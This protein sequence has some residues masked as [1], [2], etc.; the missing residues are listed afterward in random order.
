[1][2]RS[3]LLALWII[4]CSS[5]SLYSQATLR[6]EVFDETTGDPLIG[7][8]VVILGTT[9]GAVTDFDGQ[10]TLKTEATGPYVLQISYTGYELMEITITDPSAFTRTKLPEA[11]ILI[12]TVEVRGSRILDKQ[13]ESPLTV[14]SLDLLAIRQTPSSNFY[15]GLGAMKDVDLTAAS[16]GFKIINTRGF[17]STSPVRSLQIIDGVDNQAPGLNFSLGNFLGAS[18]LDVLKVD[19]IVG[20]S[21]AYYGPNAFN[22]VIS[23]ET[24]NPFIHKGLSGMVRLGE[25]N[26]FEGSIRYA[27]ALRNKNGDDVF[28]YKLNFFALRADDWEAENYDPISDSRVPANNPGRFDAVNIYGD[29]YYPFSDV[30]LSSAHLVS[31]PGIGNFYRTG[32]REIDLVDYN[33]RNYKA[34]AAFHLRTNASRGVESP[35]LIL[36]S[37]FGS[38]TTVYQ[39]DNRFSLRDILFFQN[40]I[41]FRKRDKYFIRAYATHED[42]GNSFD[43]YFTALRLQELSKTDVDWATDYRRF[44][45]GI[46]N[47]PRTMRELGYPVPIFDPVTGIV[48]FDVAG[49]EQWLVNNHDSLAI[50]H[51]I[52][53]AY[54]NTKNT[55]IEKGISDFLAPGT[56]EF[57]AAFNDITGRLNNEDG[58]TKFYDKSALY[59]VHGEYTFTP[60]FISEIRV[61]GNYRLYTPHSKGTIF[62]DSTTNIRNSEMGFYAGL[63]EKFI[64]N[65]LTASATMRMDKNENLDWIATPAASLVYKPGKNTYVR[66]SFSSALRNPTL[67]DQ[68]LN[69]NVGPA[70]LAGQI[71]GVDSLL[72]IDSFLKWLG[73]RK[74]SDLVYFNIDGIRPEKV[75]TLETGIRTTLFKSLFVDMGY[76]T[77]TYKDFLGYQLGIRSVI[78]FNDPLAFPEETVVYRYAANSKTKVKTQGFSIGL[79]Y[80][81]NQRFSV[82]GN[83]SFN[84]L[85]KLDADDPI[86]PAYNTPENK[87]NLGFSGRNIQLLDMDAFRKFGFSINYKWVEGFVFEGSPQFTGIVP[88]YD[89]LDA[90]VSVELE[91]INTTIK[92]GASNILNNKHFETYGGPY[93][94][95]LAYINLLYEFKKE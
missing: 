80:Y 37:S 52:A 72:T 4:L 95:R 14:E 59:H 49:A 31:D 44:W 91:S 35:E 65:K 82:N 6:G 17:N 55:H 58:G 54:A 39:G 10:Y 88:S 34:N 43:P 27:D 30:T 79:N 76:Y 23:M 12:E 47:Y 73:T 70:T 19:I 46:A 60:R 90:Q 15:D 38:G 33:T 29:E 3:I 22:G 16:L 1:M 5:A 84:E 61:G 64:Q 66:V 8:N 20:A 94:G 63:Q 53:E 24:K 7:A 18:E 67:S 25:R 45:K 50:W 68:Y 89:L 42:A 48:S 2:Q 75:K 21:G 81:I 71:N 85:T 74:N 51:S 77:N 86:I 11:S 26:L 83:Y 9:S 41:E 13:K 28:A 40:R 69:L 87:F 56:P 57:E 78:N 93:I 32:Y 36:S 92:V 62:Y